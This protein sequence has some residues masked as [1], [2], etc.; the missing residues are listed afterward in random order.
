MPIQIIRQDITRVRCDAI[1]NTS[2]ESLIPGGGVDLAIHT[3]AGPKLLSACEKLNGCELG[4]AKITPAF[5]LPCKYVIHTVG[6]VWQGGG[7]GERALLESCY[8]KSLQLAK[9]YRCK[10]VA[11]PLISS[12]VYGYPKDRVLDVAMRCIGEF[13]EDHEMTV[14]IVIYDRASF[15]LSEKLT[16]DIVSCIDDRYVEEHDEFFPRISRRP[17]FEAAK[18][19]HRPME[20]ESKCKSRAE[21]DFCRVPDTAPAPAFPSLSLEEMLGQ[22]DESFSEM[23]LR[24]IDESGMKDSECYKKANIDR[25]LFSKI[26]S[27]KHYK[28]SKPTVLAFAVALELPLDE[29]KDMLMKAGFALSRSNKFDIII[30]FFIEHGKYDMYEINE[31][32]FAFDQPLL[33]A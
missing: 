23:L 1:V 3:A 4:Q 19:F 15:A 13:L 29:T 6:P 25:K 20:E 30:E 18:N 11:F 9:K 21:S 17:R 28:P 16:S 7:S 32:L 5:H 27:D 33:G 10:T 26:R 12:G 22:I 24:K 14:Y 8:T 31:T 2:N